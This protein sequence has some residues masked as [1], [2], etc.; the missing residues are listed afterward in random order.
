MNRRI[1]VTFAWLTLVVAAESILAQTNIG[2]DVVKRRQETQQ[3]ARELTRELVGG[4][5]EVQLEQLE[6]NGLDD[7]PLY[8]DI[9]QM[10]ANLDGLVEAE[11]AEVVNTLVKAQQAPSDQREPLFLDARQKIR[12]VVVRLAVERQNLLRRLKNA[13]L[14]GQVR[15][16]IERESVV[17]QLTENIPQLP[18]GQKETALV[19]AIQDQRD[20]KALFMSFVTTLQDVRSW[21]GEVGRGAADAM[22][23]LQAA[24][25]GASLDRAAVSME[26]AQW[27]EA[28]QSQ[29]AVLR[30]LQLLLE[31]IEATQGLLSADREAALEL[32]R[33]LRE[34]QEK[35]N[36]ATK[37]SPLND[38]TSA[39]LVDRQLAVQK[40]LGHLPQ[41]LKQSPGL[42]NHV[43]QARKS[44]AESADKLFQNEREAAVA[45]QQDIARNLQ[46]LERRLMDD[47]VQAS[48][49]RSAAELKREVSDLQKLQKELQ[50]AR[51]KTL[52][53]RQQLPQD[54]AQARQ[55]TKQAASDLDTATDGKQLPNIVRART[56]EAADAADA[57]RESLES[58]DTAMPEASNKLAEADKAIERAMAETNVALADAT[59]R[60]LAVEAGELARA[61]EALER[62]AASEREIAQQLTKKA[63]PGDEPPSA[64]KMAQ[65]QA[66]VQQ[67]LQ[68]VNEATKDLALAAQSDLAQAQKQAEPLEKQ[69]A[70]LADKPADAPEKAAAAKQATATAQKIS[71]AADKLRQQLGQT[72][73]KLSAE[74]QRQLNQVAPL[75][76]AVEDL[77]AK[78]PA[79]LADQ[80]EKVE[81]A[82]SLVQQAQ[83]KQ[84]VAQGKQALGK[85]QEKLAALDRALSRQTE[86]DQAAEDVAQGRANSPLDAAVR[87]QR[88]AEEVA[89]AATD[90]M[91]DPALAQAKQQAE[92]AARQLLDGNQRGAKQSRRDVRKALEEAKKNA[93]QQ[94]AQAAQEPAG[95][96]DAQAQRDVSDLVAKAQEAARPAATE[97]EGT[98]AQAGEQSNQAAKQLSANKPTEAAPPQQAAAAALDEAAKQ[99]AAKRNELAQAVQNA[100]AE[101]RKQA[102]ELARQAVGVDSVAQAA[103]RE[104][105]KASDPQSGRNTPAA[106]ESA[107]EAMQ[108]EVAEKLAKL[109]GAKA[110]TREAMYEQLKAMGQSERA[111]AQRAV[112]EIA[113]VMKQ[114]EAAKAA[115]SPG[116]DQPQANDAA[117][118]KQRQVAKAAARAAEE[119][120]KQTEKDKSATGEAGKHLQKAAEAAQRAAERLADGRNDDAQAAQKDVQQSLADASKEALRAAQEAATQTPQKAD[121]RAQRKAIDATHKAA[122][123]AAG[124]AQ[125]ATQKL[126]QAESAGKNAERQI[127]AGKEAEGR[128][129]QRKSLD[130]LEKSLADLDARQQQL[131]QQQQKLAQNNPPPMTPPADGKSA[132]A[133]PQ[134]AASM[135]AAAQKAGEA[136][137]RAAATLHERE[138]R[139]RQDQALADEVRKAAE[140]QRDAAQQIADARSTLQ[141]MAGGAPGDM[142]PM[143]SPA[144]KPGQPMPAGKPMNGGAGKPT[145]EQAA[146]AADQLAQAVDNF[147]Q[148]QQS[149]GEAAEQISGQ[150]Q[151]ANPPLRE[152]LEIASTLMPESATPMPGEENGA[153][154]PVPS[155]GASNPQ[156]AGQAKDD[157][158]SPPPAPGH[159]GTNLVPASPEATAQMMAGKAALEQMAAAQGRTPESTNRPQDAQG[160]NNSQQASTQSQP[161]SDA[162]NPLDGVSPPNSTPAEKGKAAGKDTGD[163]AL[164]LRNFEDQPWFLKLPAETRAAI[165]AQAQRS[166]PRGYEERL[167]RYFRSVE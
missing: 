73:Q 58:A 80:L 83:A 12:E 139:V 134:S 18:Q 109:Q 120:A 132:P 102:A 74:A 110:K 156:S 20:V 154:T 70:A 52:A 62:A 22:D 150:Q 131:E 37:K 75:R 69:L 155:Q 65:E 1:T 163:Q 116:D 137:E 152:A 124:E 148:A 2:I 21:G 108:E 31:R 136:V 8:R 45:A 63:E 165:R 66:A 125:D 117:A 105:E 100:M 23:I 28:R 159:L 119:L 85:A 46:E 64:Q 118:A 79:S 54:R 27:P 57:A 96:P 101:Q 121:L 48:P 56:E 166:P 90:P 35:V 14:A 103:L 138:Q 145:P 38:E 15:R 41:L 34:R 50:S 59:R 3:R 33:E 43:E 157:K 92:T 89:K 51:Q 76:Q 135:Q 17:H 115:T 167:K 7:M 88:A 151:V 68:K 122:E 123:M 5:L 44:A 81:A 147:A 67:V 126:A 77:A 99:L 127:A 144:G 112:D 53:A 130:A 160:Q 36:E 29:L 82:Q 40:D 39:P 162:Q 84:N 94:V 149:I 9:K 107:A 106:A 60:Q 97:A 32:V 26:G 95:Q 104:A 87:Q 113:G 161:K 6:E 16:L 24:Q 98:L 19:D 114:Q 47:V 111:A 72:A 142:P 4:V 11:M 141:S 146:Q 140:A 30:G 133:A 129:D 158:G 13:E 71:A 143:N 10:R 91:A 61:A 42:L 164:T 128:D 25:I 86:A 55:T 93:Q 153:G 78:K 49:D